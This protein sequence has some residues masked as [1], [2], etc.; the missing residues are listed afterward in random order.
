MPLI[1]CPVSLI[2]CPLGAPVGGG[3]AQ[4]HLMAISTIKRYLQRP[5]R[6]DR[7]VWFRNHAQLSLWSTQWLL[8][9]CILGDLVILVPV[10]FSWWTHFHE[11][12][13]ILELINS[14]M[15]CAR[16]Q[17]MAPWHHHLYKEL[18]MAHVVSQSTVYVKT[19][20]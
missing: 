17:I 19:R 1:D 11:M 9:G 16:L 10:Q 15:Q 5:T 13:Q 18:Y 14:V 7:V 2:D 20:G 4:T 12:P 8:C 3:E 6:H